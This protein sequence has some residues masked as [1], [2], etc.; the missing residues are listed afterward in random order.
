MQFELPA[1]PPPQF[2][3]HVR[4][5][6]DP[7]AQFWLQLPAWLQSTLQVDF[8]S[9]L[10]VQP[11]SFAQFVVHV[12]PP[13]VRLQ[14]FAVEQSMLQF[15]PAVHVAAQLGS[16]HAWLQVVPVQVMVEDESPLHAV[17]TAP[18][19]TNSAPVACKA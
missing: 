11:P 6:V 7:P 2:S 17:T 18:R 4:L 13:Q 16:V 3:L 19:A 5:H 9:Q 10:A 12:E 1:Q 14:E 8:A 15:A